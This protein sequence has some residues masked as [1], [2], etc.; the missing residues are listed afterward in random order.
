MTSNEIFFN[1]FKLIL[2]KK[3]WD[4]VISYEYQQVWESLINDKTTNYGVRNSDILE[5]RNASGH[6]V[7]FKHKGMKSMKKWKKIG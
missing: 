4:Q 6:N 7:S 5:K 2:W 3:T 1:L